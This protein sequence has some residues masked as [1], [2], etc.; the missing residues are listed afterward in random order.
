MFCSLVICKIK[1]APHKA[2]TIPRLELLGYFL[3]SKLV[4]SV[5]RAIRMTVKVDEVYFCVYFCINLSLM[6]QIC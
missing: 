1:V 4:D 5:K 2:L 3:Q 6:D